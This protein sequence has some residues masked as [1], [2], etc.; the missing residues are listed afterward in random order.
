MQ[1][2][3]F[4]QTLLALL[5]A[6]SPGAVTACVSAGQNQQPVT[7]PHLSAPVATV[8]VHNDQ[9]ADMRVYIVDGSNAEYRLGTVQAMSSATFK[10][11]KVISSPSDL[12]FFVAS[13]TSGE[14]RSSEAVSVSSG[15]AVEFTIGQTR[16]LSSL[17]VRR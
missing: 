16:T 9:L 12:R 10:V 17:F 5:T 14:S 13:L 15:S 2:I 4:H 8:T 6:V 3:H 7:G 11:P 1:T